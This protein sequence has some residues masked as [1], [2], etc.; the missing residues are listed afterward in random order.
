MPNEDSV[1]ATSSEI[2]TGGRASSSKRK[3][4]AA[5]YVA[6]GAGG[7]RAVQDLRFE[8][9]EWPISFIASSDEAEAW[10]A[11]LDA[12][13]DDRGW[14]SSSFSQLD[15]AENSGTISVYTTAGPSSSMVEI[16]WERL[17][18]ATLHIR[19]RPGGDASLSL[20]EARAFIEAV[21]ERQ[22]SGKTARSSTDDPGLLWASMAWRASAG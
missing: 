20:D 6:D 19:A 5:V 22:L 1:P 9:D 15:A 18:D 13:V 4:D 10:M 3:A 2:E 7:L 21:R 11:Q 17:R 12:E 16:V 8:E 14:A